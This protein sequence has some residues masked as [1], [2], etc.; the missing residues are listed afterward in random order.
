MKISEVLAIVVIMTVL[1]FMMT[2]ILGV[3]IPL[4][5]DVG[6]SRGALVAVQQLLSK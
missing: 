4:P 1:S 6:R 2:T 5:E 3:C